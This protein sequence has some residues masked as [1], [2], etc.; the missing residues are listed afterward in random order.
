MPWRTGRYGF[1]V[2][3]PGP[4]E[5]TMRSLSTPE[6]L[7]CLPG[8][9]FVLYSAPGFYF[10][11]RACRGESRRD[12][13]IWWQA[14]RS[15]FGGGQSVTAHR[16]CA[17]KLRKRASGQAHAGMPGLYFFATE[18][19]LQ[20]RL[21]PYCTMLAGLRRTPS[22]HFVCQSLI[23]LNKTASLPPMCRAGA[24]QLHRDVSVFFGTREIV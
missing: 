7:H 18:Y 3:P 13:F 9:P 17:P 12:A 19:A 8:N 22:G 1:P 5:K 21:Y 6:C 10:F 24:W 4:D 14:A 20:Q 2:Y 11:S 15:R 23:P 16:G